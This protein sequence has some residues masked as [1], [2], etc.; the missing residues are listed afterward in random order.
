VA[1][2]WGGPHIG[3]R[4]DLGAT[5]PD[6]TI[7]GGPGERI[8][9]AH[10]T[11]C[12]CRGQ[13]L[14][15]ADVTGDGANDILIGAPQSD[16][17]RGSVIVLAGPVSGG[18]IDTSRVPVTRVTSALADGRL[19]WSVATGHLDADA[20]LDVVVAAPWASAGGA[21]RE[22]LVYGIRGPLPAAGRLPVDAAS[23][24]VAGPMAGA[25]TAGATLAFADLN[26]DDADDLVLGFPDAAP[27]GRN[28]SGAVYILCGPVLGGRSAATRTTT[29][30]G[31]PVEP[32]DTPAVAT[33]ATTASATPT[34]PAG[35]ALPTPTGL[36]ATT[37][38]TPTGQAV[39][40]TAAPSATGSAAGT[41]VPTPTA[42]EQPPPG[43]I[44]DATSVDPTAIDNPGSSPTPGRSPCTRD[45]SGNARAACFPSALNQR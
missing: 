9:M 39:T 36:A 27:Y 17:G 45:A 16:A 12:S 21:S 19:G 35:T 5:D 26:H 44:P 10:G 41:P 4:V 3:G 8:G 6:V 20:F 13:S 29:P 33:N 18:L 32:S 40:V 7:V 22:G 1:V 15:V 42:D 25:G 28:A 30:M 14:Q 37:A 38:S 43:P 34:G 11:V 2:F 31:T 24:F 23:L